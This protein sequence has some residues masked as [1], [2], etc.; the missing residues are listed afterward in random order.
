MSFQPVDL[1]VLNAGTAVPGVVVNCYSQDGTIFYTGVTTDTDG[2]AGFLLDSA[3]S[4][5]QFRFFKMHWTFQNPQ[6]MEVL[7]TSANVF[8]VAAVDVTPPVP[9]DPRF[10]TAFGHFRD[11]TGRPLVKARMQFIPNFL[12]LT[13]DGDAVLTGHI[14]LTTDENGYAQV[15]L[16]R[17]GLY[18]CTVNAREEYVRPI[19]VPDQPNVSLPNLLFPVVDQILFTPD[20]PTTLM[21][22]AEDT[23]YLTTLHLTDDTTATVDAVQWSSSDSNVLAVIPNIPVTGQLTLRPLAPGT[24]MIQAIRSDN[25][26]IRIPDPG[27]EGVP[28]TVVVT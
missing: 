6:Y 24:A 11:I 5:Y 20:L 22:G 14:N 8:D 21:A 3:L 23:V 9:R 27:I 12:P 4:P 25:S 10:C 26:I 13:L 1:Y 16:I 2:H 17:F 18:T 28:H 7:E 15:D 19:T